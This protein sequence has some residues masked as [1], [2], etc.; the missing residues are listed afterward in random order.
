MEEIIKNETT[1]KQKARGWTAVL[2]PSSMPP[3]WEDLIE[4][5]L[6]L[7]GFYAI[8]NKD[9]SKETGELLEKHV[10]VY[11]FFPGPTT[12]NQALKHFQ[13]L[14]PS[15]TYC[16]AIISAKYAWEYSIHNT[17]AARKQ[18]KHQY[19]PS[20]RHT[21]N[22][23]NIEDYAVASPAEKSAAAKQLADLIQARKIANFME[24]YNIAISTYPETAWDAIK[25]NSG[26]YDRMCRANFLTLKKSQP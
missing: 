18:L 15:C 3:D 19:D 5:T 10:H 25:A 9:F 21:F 1:N 22:G 6:Q 23:F 12:Y 14:Q 4:E 7:P 13:R 2:Y 11:D 20:E 17:E 26:L 24:F 16:Q 8:H